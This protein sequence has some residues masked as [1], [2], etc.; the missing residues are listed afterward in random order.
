MLNL[1]LP[2]MFAPQSGQESLTGGSIL[3]VT[4]V[5]RVDL[6]L[7]LLFAAKSMQFPKIAGILLTDK[8]RGGLSPEVM[9]IIMSKDSDRTP[10]LT[11]GLDTY[12]ATQRIHGLHGL[13]PRLLPTAGVKLRAAQEIFAMNACQGVQSQPSHGHLPSFASTI[14]LALNEWLDIFLTRV[15]DMQISFKRLCVGRT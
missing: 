15:L 6:L 12:E 4:H 8:S 5:G 11:I 3:V 14:V 9:Q 7:S 2:P 10:V 13:A 1:A